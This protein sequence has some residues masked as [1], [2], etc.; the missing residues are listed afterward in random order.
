LKRLSF[1]ILSIALLAG[2][3]PVADLQ[4][5]MITT[6]EVQVATIAPELEDP[7]EPGGRQAPQQPLEQ[8]LSALSFVLISGNYARNS[9][10]DDTQYTEVFMPDKD[11]FLRI[12]SSDMEEEVFAYNYI[13]DDFTYLYYFD[14]ELLAKT[15]YNISTGE[16]KQDDGGFAKYILIDAEEL[17]TY[18]LEILSSA[19][20][21]PEEL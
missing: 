7:H 3:R 19:G 20:I 10:Q 15:V 14:G 21:L 18:C 17:K 16:V 1:I 12:A 13:S 8:R 4:D 6:F 11:N 2:C 5:E 9:I